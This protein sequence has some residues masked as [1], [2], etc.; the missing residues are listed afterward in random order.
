[1]TYIPPP[2]PE[3]PYTV[4]IQVSGSYHC[5]NC[6]RT[7]DGTAMDHLAITDAEYAYGHVH[8]ITS[9]RAV[10]HMTTCRPAPKET[11]T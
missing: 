9:R 3:P 5:P 8:Y 7:Y 4:T 10:T 1:M 2:F 6:D 11:D